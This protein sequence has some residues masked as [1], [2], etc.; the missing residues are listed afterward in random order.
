MLKPRILLLIFFLLL[1]L[2]W[3]FS[4]GFW[5]RTK[6]GWAAARLEHHELTDPALKKLQLKATDA[7]LL[8]NRKDITMLFAS[9]WI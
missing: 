4:S 7:K 1:S 2:T 8:Y 3:L 5:K 9:L 6:S